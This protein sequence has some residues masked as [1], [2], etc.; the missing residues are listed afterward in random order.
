MSGDGLRLQPLLGN[1]TV[2]RLLR[3]APVPVGDAQPRDE[4]GSAPAPPLVGEVLRSPGRPLDPAMRV[5]MESRFGQD[6][7]GVRV[8]TDP[9]AARSARAV[10]ALAYTA[11]E[12][13]VLGGGVAGGVPDRRR[14]LA[15]ELTHV[16]QQRKSGAETAPR[17]WTVGPAHGPHEREAASNA[18]AVAAGAPARSPVQSAG[19]VIQRISIWEWIARFFGGGTFPVE[20]LEEYLRFLDENDRIEDHFDS[21]N[22]ARAV[23]ARW[24]RG[25]SRFLLH[26][27]RKTL[28]IQEMLSGYVAGDDEA[29]ILALLRG[30]PDTELRSIVAAV[31]RQTLES[32]LHGDSRTQL[33]ELLNTRLTARR[34]A[35]AEP[36]AE[37]GTEVFP[38]ET[39]VRLRQRFTS[40]AE[41]E[42][43]VRL[44]CILIVR[45]VAPDLFAH[46]PALARQV[47]AALGGLRGRNLRMTEA[48]RVL[49]ELG[50]AT[51]PTVIR[52][53]GRNG[54][55]EPTA[56]TTS[57]WDTIIAQVGDDYG[58]HIF[59][60]A[61]FNGYHSVTVF[62]DN[63][64]DGPR[65]YWADQWAIGPG[66]DFRQAPGSVSGFRRYEREGFDRFINEVTNRWWRDNFNRTG[67]R[68]EA[69][70]KIWK[71]H[72][73][74]VRR[75]GGER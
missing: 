61:V 23:V 5:D 71:F 59:G 35:G 67:A 46:D 43:N 47:A 8:H 4:S 9:R 22:K 26:P 66:E 40:N 74:V 64:P 1:R 29:A 19:A 18:A 53:N 44:N 52:F 7:G 48:G 32:N 21:D 73:R 75:R 68:W 30:S 36:G 2:Q 38:P 65:V 50:V 37:G 15:H 6:F 39:I 49:T 16:L 70:L 27:R 17:R 10:D 13:V 14:V 3:R 62:V 12:H 58:W 24:V 11:G 31:G 54:I 72:N 55:E 33:D 69:S 56:M 57:A 45:D 28:L 60:M 63:R 41:L 34:P 20:E 42:H 51:G 25:E